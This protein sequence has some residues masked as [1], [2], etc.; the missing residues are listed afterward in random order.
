M[1]KALSLGTLGHQS[2]LLHP[3][4]PA[5]SWPMPVLPH[6][7]ERW[8]SSSEMKTLSRAGTL[9]PSAEAQIC[10]KHVALIWEHHLGPTPGTSRLSASDPPPHDLLPCVGHRENKC[11]PA[12]LGSLTRSTPGTQGEHLPPSLFASSC[13]C[14]SC[15]C[16]TCLSSL[17]L[18]PHLSSVYLPFL[19]LLVFLSV[20]VSL[21]LS[22]HIY[23]LPSVHLGPF[24][25]FP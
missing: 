17:S 22:L 3:V 15:L 13:V 24:C 14:P 25:L 18:V 2:L 1:Q 8:Y 16:L 4:V 21:F 20:L 9:L 7:M 10:S 19:S 5:S 12:I 11:W 23:L 6:P